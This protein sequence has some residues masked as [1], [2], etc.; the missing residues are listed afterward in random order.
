MPD[1]SLTGISLVDGEEEAAGTPVRRPAHWRDPRPHRFTRAERGRTTILFGGLTDVHE[2]ILEGALA[3][4]G[5]RARALPCPDK[6]AL[7][8]GKEF[9]NRGQCNPTYFTVGNL[10][11]HLVALRD[12]RGM[13]VEEIVR[14]HVFV[15]L[16]SCGPCRFGMYSTEY[17]KALRDAGF[18]GFRVLDIKQEYS[19]TRAADEIGLEL[20]FRFYLTFLRALFAGDVINAICYR[21]RPYEVVPGA[22]DAARAGAVGIVREAFAKRRGVRRALRRARALFAGVEVDRLQPKPKVAIIG[23]FWAMTTEGEGNYFLQSFLEREGAECEIPLVT[24]WVFYNIWCVKYDIRQLMWLKRR[25]GERHRRDSAHPLRTLFLLEVARRALE[26]MFSTYARAIGLDGYRLPAMD[27]VA[28]TSHGYYANELRGGEG[29]MEVGKVL[30][31]AKKNKAHMIVSVKPFGCMPSSAVSDGVQSL[32]TARHPEANFLAVE[33]TGDGAVNVYSRI[34]MALFKARARAQAEFEA[35]LAALG[36]SAEE[37]RARAARDARL[38][39]AT[40]YPRHV[41]AGTAA[42]ALHELAGRGGKRRTR[43]ALTR[44]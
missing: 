17:R 13:S 41:T 15:T 7:Q 38:R 44:S 12:E 3:G 25:E 43:A 33:T 35:A 8:Y 14:D 1:R 16:G 42:N 6:S 19:P 10:I 5:Y 11:R 29:H 2:E 26:R 39:R 20:N 18:A 30:E 28:A 22:T 27:T 36:L 4:L 40:H 23:E 34:Q 37:A 31:T 24:T 9:G 21:T 32:V